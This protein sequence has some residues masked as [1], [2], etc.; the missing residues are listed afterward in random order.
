MVCD[1]IDPVTKQRYDRDP[2]YIARKAEKYLGSTGLADTAYFGAEAE[3]F[4]F[5]NVRFD[6][7][8]AHG[9]Y[10][11]DAEEGRWNSGRAENN[12]GYKPRYKEG[13]FPGAANGPLSGHA[14][15]DG[16]DDDKLRSGR[17]V[18]ASRS[19]HSRPERNRSA[20]RHA[21]EVGRPHDAVQV[22]HQECR[23]PARQNRYVHA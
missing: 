23:Q 22:H 3:F 1:V 8:V 15:R 18:S 21:G 9:F 13:Y 10:F 19:G 16:H 14:Q 12:L 20:I 6:Q 17:R 11:I 7:N 5:D 2:R 4:I